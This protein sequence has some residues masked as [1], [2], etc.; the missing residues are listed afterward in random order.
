[1]QKVTYKSGNGMQASDIAKDYK[2][3]MSKSV[4]I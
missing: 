2:Y 3:R 4:I 1:M